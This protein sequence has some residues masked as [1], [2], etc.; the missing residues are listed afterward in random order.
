MLAKQKHKA[1]RHCEH[2]QEVYT[3]NRTFDSSAYIC[4]IWSEEIGKKGK[5]EKKKRKKIRHGYIRRE[6]CESTTISFLGYLACSNW[7]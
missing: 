6:F 2:I 3:L 5:S 4:H 7:L 1:D